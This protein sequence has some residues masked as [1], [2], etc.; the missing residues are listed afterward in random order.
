MLRG[1]SIARELLN[2]IL[3]PSGSIS[4]GNLGLTA[5]HAMAYMSPN[6]TMQIVCQTP[7]P[8]LGVTPRYNPF[9]PLLP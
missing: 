1:D 3:G 4:G 9:S 2:S 6:A 7:S 5:E 8:I